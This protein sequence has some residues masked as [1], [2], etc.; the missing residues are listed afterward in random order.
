MSMASNQDHR[1]MRKN[2][3]TSSAAKGNEVASTLA[4]VDYLREMTAE[5]Y[6]KCSE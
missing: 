1:L 6:C 5:K 3:H 2:C 4:V